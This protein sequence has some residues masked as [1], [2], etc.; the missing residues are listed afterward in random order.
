ME[1]GLKKIALATL[2]SGV[3][4]SASLAGNAKNVLLIC[5]DD[6]RPELASFGAAY[7]KSPNIGRL[8]SKGRPFHRHYVNAPSCGPPRATPC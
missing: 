8:A 1:T 7:I 4:A 5:M 6:L 2:L 3:A